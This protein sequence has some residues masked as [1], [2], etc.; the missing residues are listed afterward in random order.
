MK[1]IWPLKEE[2]RSEAPGGSFQIPTGHSIPLVLLE[3]PAGFYSEWRGKMT[4]PDCLPCPNQ[5]QYVQ[6]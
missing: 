3:R 5:L 4:V 1:L 6:K 2:E